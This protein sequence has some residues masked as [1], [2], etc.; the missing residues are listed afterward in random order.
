MS[1]PM[2]RPRN[3]RPSYKIFESF[4][5][6]KSVGP[7]SKKKK[8]LKSTTQ[9]RKDAFSA[10]PG[11]SLTRGLVACLSRSLAEPKCTAFISFFLFP[12]NFYPFCFMASDDK[13]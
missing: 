3:I 13:K 6:F 1:I 9:D 12:L 4:K 2:Q 5:S 11:A 7:G 10:F 8:K